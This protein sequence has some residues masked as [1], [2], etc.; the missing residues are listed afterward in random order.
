MCVKSFEEHREVEMC[1]KIWYSFPMRVPEG[2]GS[3]W[4]AISFEHFI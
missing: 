3:K 2:F 4:P 1:N